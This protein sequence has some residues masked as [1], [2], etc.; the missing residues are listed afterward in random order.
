MRKAWID[1]ALSY[2]QVHGKNRHETC[3]GMVPGLVVV[4]L[5]RLRWWG[6]AHKPFSIVCM[7]VCPGQLLS[8]LRDRNMSDACLDTL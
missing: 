6:S 1:K 2:M 4:M 5:R 3:T 8:I 7:A